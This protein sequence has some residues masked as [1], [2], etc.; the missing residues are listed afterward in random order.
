MI[1]RAF[2]SLIVAVAASAMCVAPCDAALVRS[3]YASSDPNTGPD[4]N[5]SG[6]GSID[7]WS[8][9]KSTT[10]ASQA[11]S[12]LGDSAGNAGGSGA[13][14]GASAWALYANSGQSSTASANIAALMGRALFTEG[15]AIS[16]DFDNGW[17]DNGGSVGIRFLDSLGAV[18]SSLKFTGGIANYRLSDGTSSDHDTDIGFTGDGFNVNLTL[19]AAGEYAINIGGTD[20]LGRLLGGS[21]DIAT[22]EVFNENAGSFS[23]RNLFFNNLSLTAV[24]EISSALTMPLL[25]GFLLRRGRGRR[26]AA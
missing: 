24:P 25:A 8:V 3:F 15:D 23:E 7:L 12:F 16:I 9:T 2:T 19:E 17:I 11:G 5:E 14:A 4:A 1:V 20:V 10:D 22:V 6:A 18:A 13:G 21:K 26:S